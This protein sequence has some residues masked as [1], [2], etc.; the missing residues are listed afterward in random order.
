LMASPTLH[1]GQRIR[2]RVEAAGDNAEPVSC[3]LVIMHYSGEDQLVQATGP[4]TLLQPGQAA[5]LVWTAP[6][7]GGQPIESIGIAIS[8]ADDAGIVYLDQLTWDGTPDVSFERPSD[9]GTMWRRAWVDALDDFSGWWPEPYRLI[10]NAGRGMIIQGT[11]EW[12]DY[13][14]TATVRPHM[15]DTTG[16]A[17]RVQ[18]LQRYYA[19]LLGSDG[20]A[21]LVKVLDGEQTLAQAPMPWILDRDYELSL[22]VT[23]N[24]IVA[25]VDGTPIATAEDTDRP[26]SGGAI[27]LV[28]ENGRAD[29]DA[30]AVNPVR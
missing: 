5:D 20:I 10:K 18:G 6:S 1:P 11:R 12:Q 24:R 2:A 30:V 23:G 27:G 26:L 29:C 7:T 19:L 22:T 8:G 16:I 21:R 9:G 13:Q 4:V 14:V 17:A 25:A 15:A 28:V 3:G